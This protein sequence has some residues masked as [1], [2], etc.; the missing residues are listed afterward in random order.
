MRKVLD[1]IIGNASLKTKLYSDILSQTLSHAYIIEGKKG[2]GKHTVSYLIAAALSC[3][4]LNDGNSAIPCGTCKSCK[5]ILEGKSPDVIMITRED[6]ASIGVDAVRFL[7]NDV[8]VVPNDLEYK[9]YIIEDADAMT[10]QAQNAFLL[11]L[12]EPPSYVKFFLLCE[13]ADSLLE[14]VRSRSQIL[15]TEPISTEDIDSYLQSNY[16]AAKQMKLSDPSDYYE[17]IMSSGASIGRAVELLDSKTFKKT[18]EERNIARD[19][20][21]AITSKPSS[22]EIVSLLYKFEKKRDQLIDLL[23][24]VE[25]ALR[26]IIAIDR[27][28]NAPLLFFYDRQE[29]LSLSDAINIRKLMNIYD[30][31][32]NLQDLINSN[33]NIRLT[34]TNFFSEINIL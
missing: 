6:K 30:R 24:T 19:F 20:L 23:L 3:E 21:K 8:R 11:T 14:T 34:V 18:L 32:K 17:L 26:D 4:N 2:S 5:K 9:I 25:L 15:K 16:Q 29:A 28:E 13:D 27:T 1:S 33:T 7:R 10:Q 31:L 22:D 12:E